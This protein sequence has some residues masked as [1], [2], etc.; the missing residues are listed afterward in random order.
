MRD[1]AGKHFKS[2]EL[3]VLKTQAENFEKL[4]SHKKMT[5]R[6]TNVENKGLASS[7]LTFV[8]G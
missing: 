4:E 1:G 3:K 8:L 2:V 6:I 5:V 7:S